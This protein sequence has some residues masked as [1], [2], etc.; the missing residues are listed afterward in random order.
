M[1]LLR[2]CWSGYCGGDDARHSRPPP[3]FLP[4]IFVIPAPHLSHSRPRSPSFL[5]PLSSFPRRRESILTL[6]VGTQAR[7][8]KAQTRF[9]KST[10]DPRVREDDGCVRIAVFVR[11]AGWGI[12]AHPSTVIP[13]QAGIHFDLVGRHPSP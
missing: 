6:W 9:Y 8:Q 3:S 12:P 1:G 5:P 10:M 4:Q 2:G 13:A 11:M 7:E